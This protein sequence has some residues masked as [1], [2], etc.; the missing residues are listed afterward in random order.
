MPTSRFTDDPFETSRTCFT[1]QALVRPES[2]REPPMQEVGTA[3]DT[4]RMPLA[5]D[6]DQ[7]PIAAFEERAGDPIAPSVAARRARCNGRPACGAYDGSE[8]PRQVVVTCSGL[9]PEERARAEGW[10]AML[11]WGFS[12]DLRKQVTHI[13]ATNAYTKKVLVGRCHGIWVLCPSWLEDSWA[14]QRHCQEDDYVLRPL[15][16]LCFSSAQLEDE[17]ISQLQALVAKH[18]ATYKRNPNMECTHLVVHRASGRKVEYAERHQIILLSFQWLE[19]CERTQALVDWHLYQMK[20]N[21]AA[22][23]CADHDTTNRSSNSQAVHAGYVLSQHSSLLRQNTCLGSPAASY[24][25]S[26]G[27]KKAD[28]LISASGEAVSSAANGHRYEEDVQLVTREPTHN[29]SVNG[30]DCCQVEADE[31]TVQLQQNIRI[32]SAESSQVDALRTP[33]RPLKEAL[34][35]PSLMENF[36]FFLFGLSESETRLARAL[37]R[38]SGATY[39]RLWSPAI[40]HVISMETIPND[41]AAGALEFF[42]VSKQVGVLWCPLQWLQKC[43]NT[44]QIA[45]PEELNLDRLLVSASKRIDHGSCADTCSNAEK[46]VMTPATSPCFRGMNLSLLPLVRDDAVQ[47]ARLASKLRAI[48]ANVLDGQKPTQLHLTYASIDFAVTMHGG[49]R[50]LSETRGAPLVTPAWIQDCLRENTLHDYLSDPRYQPLPVPVPIEALLGKSICVSGFFD[51]KRTFFGPHGDLQMLLSRAAIQILLELAGA[52]YSERLRHRRTDYLICERPEGKKYE[53]AMQWN[54]PVVRIS[55]LLECVSSGRL[56]DV[57]THQFGCHTNSDAESNRNRRLSLRNAVC[58]LKRFLSSD[59]EITTTSKQA[60]ATA[61]EA[62]FSQQDA[63]ASESQRSSQISPKYL[64]PTPTEAPMER[65]GTDAELVSEKAI[66]RQREDGNDAHFEMD[67]NGP[68]SSRATVTSGVSVARGRPALKS[69]QPRDSGT[70]ECGTKSISAAKLANFFLG[71][72]DTKAPAR[73][74]DDGDDI[75][76]LVTGEDVDLLPGVSQIVVYSTNDGTSA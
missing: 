2:L 59:T 64:E 33:G 14:Q 60:R 41:S 76:D 47:A 17:E 69:D 1:G 66:A 7:T 27:S 74:D 55:W 73:L 65:T 8:N 56:V 12:H 51:V 34:T 45:P 39:H 50:R 21:S 26:T 43:V 46:A 19:E 57:D 4:E 18:G 31:A 25:K 61:Q 53:K 67:P 40:T 37:I 6:A 29:I 54:I 22:A 38:Q 58:G 11:G 28:A 49:S 20:P 15:A 30:D 10:C 5:K 70:A 72:L 13:I 16:G 52:E 75:D 48:G 63:D 68:L 3:Q 23:L 32:V 42:E 44:Q 62:P 24:E 71:R 36:N 9:T 35:F